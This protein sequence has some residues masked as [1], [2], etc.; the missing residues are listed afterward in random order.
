ME[1]YSEDHRGLQDQF[2]SRPL[3]DRLQETIVESEVGELHQP[4][5]E[6]RDFFFLSTVNAAGEPTVS[7]KGGDEGVLKVVDA[8]TLAFPIY[9]GNGMFLSAGNIEGQTKIGLLLI[10]FIT[11]NR[12]R[13]Q[14]GATLSHDDPLMAEWPGAVTIVRCA[15]DSVFL[16]C[17][18]Y[19]HKHERVEDSPYVP[20]ANGEAPHPSWKRIDLMQDVLTEAEIARTE[21]SGGEITLDDYAEKLLAGES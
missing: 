18:R 13:V 16:N 8:K 6:S 5:I 3:A 21:A 15:V 19:I 20:D 9:D 14:G 7:Y 2:G 10:D 12:L 1:F 11:P 4:F 17:G